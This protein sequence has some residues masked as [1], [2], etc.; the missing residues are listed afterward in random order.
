MYYRLSLPDIFL[1][2]PMAAIMSIRGQ[3]TTAATNQRHWSKDL[4]PQSR[5]SYA[6]TMKNA[7]RAFI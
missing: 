7:V 2:A 3:R 1:A 4:Y 6:Q 5:A